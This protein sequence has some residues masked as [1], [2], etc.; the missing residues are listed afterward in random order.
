[1]LKNKCRDFYFE[2]GLEYLFMQY[3]TYISR[4]HA[5]YISTPW[6]CKNMAQKS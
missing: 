3:E 1:M 6:L 5:F 4:E 2:L